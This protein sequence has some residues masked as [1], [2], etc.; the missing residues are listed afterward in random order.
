[1]AK[2]IDMDQAKQVLSLLK[3]GVDP[4]VIS[5]EMNLPYG[6]IKNIIRTITKSDTKTHKHGVNHGRIKREMQRKA[7]RSLGI[8][9]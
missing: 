3:N 1:M 8:R 5:V 9:K 4:K 2:S 7:A 6:T